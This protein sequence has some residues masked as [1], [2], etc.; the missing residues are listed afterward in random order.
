MDTD[1]AKITMAR[2]MAS[3]I[4]AVIRVNGIRFG[5]GRLQGQGYNNHYI[6]QW[7]FGWLGLNKAMMTRTT[8][9]K[10]TMDWMVPVLISKCKFN[11]FIHI[12]KK[13]RENRT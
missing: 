7:M 6:L 1:M 5:I 4:T 12:L 11:V 8:L 10:V 2:A 13:L 3:D 9:A